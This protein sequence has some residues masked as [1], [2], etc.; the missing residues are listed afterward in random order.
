MDFDEY[1]HALPAQ[2]WI[3]SGEPVLPSG[4]AYRRGLPYTF[5]VK[6]SV[7]TFGL[8]EFSVRLPSLIGGVLLLIL[9][10]WIAYRWY[11]LTA[12][13]ITLLIF[14][15]DP[16]AIQMSR[17]SRMYSV[18]HLAYLAIAYLL[19]FLFEEARN[20]RQVFLALAAIAGLSL[21][22]VK[23]HQL[24]VEVFVGVGIYLVILS[25]VTRKAKYLIPTVLG[26]LAT[27]AA[28]TLKTETFAGLWDSVN[29]APNYARMFRYDTL[30]YVREFWQVNP[31]LVIVAV[32]SLIWALCKDWKTGLFLG[33]AALVPFALHSFVFDW[34]EVRYALHMLPPLL[35]LVG[36]ALA[37]GGKL[38]IGS[39]RSA[40]RPG[41]PVSHAAAFVSL[42][43]AAPMV[44]TGLT[45]PRLEGMDGEVAQWKEA[46]A[47]V[48]PRI[49]EKDVLLTSVPFTTTFY[50]DREPDYILLNTLIANSGR[51]VERQPDGWFYDWY[52][53]RPMADDAEKM[54]QVLNQHP[55]GWVII[56]NMRYRY[57]NCVPA[58][59]RTLIEERMTEV[60]APDESIRIF[61]WGG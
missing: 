13:V 1:L 44:W 59:V 17:V 16:F 42:M 4:E 14:S 37:D 35:I 9:A 10:A 45:Q 8:S 46:F 20:K 52:S 31:W 48:G 15:V 33:L 55:S 23:L 50:L 7:Q 12:A 60:E 2:A 19:F 27:A 57:D 11:G 22:S 32:P 30:Y 26:I 56:D 43:L 58:P 41:Q 21:F 47:A 3:E 6:L 61:R 40:V 53:G 18:F 24:T 5:L 39:L 28:L 38:L 34:K 36:G 25:A 29:S 49:D 51:V 54:R